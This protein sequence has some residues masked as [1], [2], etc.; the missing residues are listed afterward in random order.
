M[1]ILRSEDF[2]ITTWVGEASRKV[3]WNGEKP[4][5]LDTPLG[6]TIE[7]HNGRF[8]IRNSSVGPWSAQIADS[9]ELDIPEPGVR[10]MIELPIPRAKGPARPLDVEIIH[11]RP[12]D[13]VYLLRH[14]LAP[15]YPNKV[16]KQLMMFYGERYYLVRY[17][18]VPPT[19][20]VSDGSRDVF[21]YVRTPTGYAVIALV[22]GVSL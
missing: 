16:P 21:Q 1:A 8:R 22:H 2:L 13:P 18:P 20:T 17:R 19:R 9:V 11:M 4:H 10:Q 5:D 12:P 15:Q 6:W 14:A 7:R 3:I